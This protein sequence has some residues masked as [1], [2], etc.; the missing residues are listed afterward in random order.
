MDRWRT[1]ERQEEPRDEKILRFSGSH[2]LAL[3]W[4]A[5]HFPEIAPDYTLQLN[6][7]GSLGGL[8]ALAEG[9]ADLAGSHL[10]DEENDCYNTPFVRRL[11][12]GKRVAVITLARR[13]LGLILAPGNPLGIESVP[14][15]AKPGLRFV[16]RQPGS[17]TRV[18]MD[19]ALRRHD[20]EPSQIAGYETEKMTHSAV[21][22][23]VAEN[24]ADAGLGLEGA[25]LSYGLDFLFLTH[26]QYD[27][28]AL[29]AVL[30]TPALAAL[31]SWLKTPSTRQAIEKLGG[32]ETSET[33][34][35]NWAG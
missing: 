15:L 27:L 6:F 10:W 18:W 16:N 35:V 33:G 29:E 32:Y 5:S 4:L 25:A 20:L 13:R 31:V 22:Q 7:S 34:Q 24:T 1:V 8:I 11:L 26:E 2:D 23:A 3:T 21:A 14:D 12:P 19:M 9:K 17:G 28:I 30:E